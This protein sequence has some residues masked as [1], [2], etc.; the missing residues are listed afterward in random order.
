MIHALQ[1]NLCVCLFVVALCARARAFFSELYA[2]Y[3]L[4]H[5][6]V[7]CPVFG[8]II[9]S[10][11]YSHLHMANIK[12]IY[13]WFGLQVA[14]DYTEVGRCCVY[15]SYDSIHPIPCCDFFPFIFLYFFGCIYWAVFGCRA[16]NT[17]NRIKNAYNA[18]VC[19]WTYEKWYL[20]G[21]RRMCENRAVFFEA[22]SN[23]SLTGKKSAYEVF[24][25]SPVLFTHSKYVVFF[26]RCTSRLIILV[27]GNHEE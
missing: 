6:Y 13:M 14:I 2:H 10:F 25:R 17:Q 27:N 24:E 23:H 18:I 21:K 11:W 26:S 9:F 8:C 7:I 3:E 19:W 5:R 22:T 1:V 15:S 20:W 4:H 12:Y 16:I